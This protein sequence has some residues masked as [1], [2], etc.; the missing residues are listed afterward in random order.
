MQNRYSHILFDLDGTL[1]DTHDVDVISLYE[2][3]KEYFPD[4]LETVESL[5]R[6]FGLPAYEALKCIGF[7]EDKIPEVYAKW[8]RAIE[9]RAGTVKLFDGVLAVLDILKKRGV[10]LGIITSRKRADY[11]KYGIL[12]DYIPLE[13]SPYFIKAVCSD[14]VKNPKP[15]PDSLLK[16]MQ[17]TGAKPQEILFIGDTKTDCECADQAG[18]D[19]ALALWGYTQREHLNCAYYFASPWSILSAAVD[20]D[21]AKLMW[22]KWAREI[23]AIGQI[24]LAYSKDR[25]DIER[26]TRLREIAL[27]IMHTYT[28]APLEKIKEAFCFDKGYITPKIDTRGAAF[29]DNGR[30]LLVQESS[31]LWSLPGGWCEED[32]TIFSNVVKEL[33]EE[34]CVKAVPYKLIA[35]LDRRRYNNPPLPFGIMKAFVLCRHEALAFVKNNETIERKYFGKDEL[36]LDKLRVDTTS[37]EQLMMCFAAYE[38][39][40]WQPIVD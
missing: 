28:E 21:C 20:G 23:Q 34:A 6:V 30:I 19:F 14:D 32:G 2:V 31:G 35:L 7:S 3:V 16:Y 17:D 26:F 5:G 18:V 15:S 12:G 9:S 4:T 10:K 39:K 29:D 13:L 37:Y 24:G 38:N 27:E 1:V 33:R 36:P 25:F 40:D 11:G 8:C 22:F